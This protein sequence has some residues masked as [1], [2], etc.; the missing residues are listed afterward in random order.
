M[1][2][3]APIDPTEL[4][5]EYLRQCRIV[6]DP[7]APASPLSRNYE[8][9]FSEWA[10]VLGVEKED[11]RL[12]VSFTPDAR[13]ETLEFDDRRQVVVYDQYL[14]QSFNRLND[15]VL[16]GWPSS[17][18]TRWGLKHLGHALAA[19][20]SLQA[21]ALAL[22]LATLWHVPD[23]PGRPS[24]QD[25]ISRGIT[26]AVQEQFVLAHECVH[27]SMRLDAVRSVR[28]ELDDLVDSVVE[29]YEG[30]SALVDREVIREE[31]LEDELRVL[32]ANR[33]DT[34]DADFVELL[35]GR[36]DTTSFKPSEALGRKEHLREELICDLVATQLV[37][38]KFGREGF[39]LP[40]VI[41]SILLGFHNLTSLEVIRDQALRR[42]NGVSEPDLD[43]VMLRKS[44][45]RTLV[46]HLFSEEGLTDMLTDATNLHAERAGD[47]ILYI[48]PFEFGRAMDRIE[49]SDFGG[50][51]EAAVLHTIREQMSE[52]RES[53]AGL[54]PP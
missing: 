46:P 16:R 44:F 42:K 37:A 12:L 7:V 5:A 8:A 39:P 25:L 10:R 17:Y 50:A 19:A 23:G 21:A 3:E 54:P 28:A 11:P 29:L 36:M 1:N 6:D 52:G 27:V 31:A 18:V 22:G 43:G 20:G 41:S 9:S 48:L 40:I 53:L 33:I 35:R 47:Q 14:G 24:R 15:F 26:T 32:K 38:E 45:W 13:V 51:E 4:A 34:E 30:T 2:V 49:G